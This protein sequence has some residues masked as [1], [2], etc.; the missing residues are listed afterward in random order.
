MFVD[1]NLQFDKRT[2]VCD[3]VECHFDGV[4]LPVHVQNPTCFMYFAGEA[5]SQR[6]EKLY[7]FGGIIRSVTQRQLDF[8]AS[9][10]RVVEF[11][12]LVSDE[13]RF[14]HSAQA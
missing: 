1:G 2:K 7:E 14:T 3:I 10:G 8:A 4:A 11:W 5:K 12:S 9:L 6:R 13:V